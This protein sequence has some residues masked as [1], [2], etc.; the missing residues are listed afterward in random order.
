VQYDDGQLERVVLQNEKFKLLGSDSKQNSG[1]GTKRGRVVDDSDD[2]G[3]VGDS[4]IDEKEEEWGAESSSEV[5]SASES[6]FALSEEDNDNGDDD[7]SSDSFDAESESSPRKRKTKTQRSRLTKNKVSRCQDKRTASADALDRSKESKSKIAKNQT[8]ISVAHMPS[9]ATPATSKPTPKTSLST[10]KQ[11][12]QG[13]PAESKGSMDTPDEEVGEVGGVYGAGAHEHDTWSFLKDQRKDKTGKPVGHPEYNPRTL[14]VS[15]RVLDEQ[16]PAMRQWFEFKVDNM[17]TILFFKVGKFYELFHM[18]ADVGVKEIDLIYMKGYKAHSGFPE[19]SYSKYSTQL[20]MKGYKVARIEQTET[21]EMLKER[22]AKKGG[23]A[24]KVVSREICAILSK[25]TR[26]YCHFDEDFDETGD[27]LTSLLIAVK[28]TW[29]ES[30]KVCEYGVCIV[31]S[32]IGKVTMAQFEDDSQRSR[33]RTLVSRYKPS[34][35][36]LEAEAHTP[37]TLGTF[38]LLAPR[39]VVDTLR[40]NEV[41]KDAATVVDAMLRAEYFPSD[42]KTGPS[43]TGRWPAVLQALVAG[44]ADGSSNLAVCALGAAIWQLRRSCIDFEILSMGKVSAYIPPDTSDD[45][46]ER[47][48]SKASESDDQLIDDDHDDHQVDAD[49]SQRHMVLDAVSLSNLEVLV[50]AYDKTEKGSLWGFINR[51]RTPFGRRLLREW[52]CKPLYRPAGIYRRSAAVNELM[53]DLSTESQQARSLLK[54]VCDLER[55]FGRVYSAGSKKRAESHPDSR[56]IMYETHVYTSKK[57]KTFGLV[58]EGFEM[59]T[60]VVDLFSATQ[61]NSPLLKRTIKSLQDGGVFPL[62]EIKKLL[63]YFRSIFDEKQAKRDGTIKPKVN[64]APLCAVHFLFANS[65]QTIAYFYF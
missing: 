36:L 27:D 7:A 23:K 59:L 3:Q 28:E 14:L 22:N 12:Y 32:I 11:L 44:L 60:K 9:S 16:T 54:G 56:A 34:E 37:E 5:G 65:I 2:I 64:L 21:P 57:I 33:L 41:P 46:Q 26:T 25:G 53:S 15:H 42:S 13:T 19:I 50:T 35:V 52:L 43:G 61:I 8:P 40:G 47:A 30:R 18:D 31:D 55:L 38:Q 45:S 10:P 48:L 49:S 1:T 17:D 62:T 6:S 29:D 4:Q 63:A 20:V 58:L 24:D 39:A 51:T